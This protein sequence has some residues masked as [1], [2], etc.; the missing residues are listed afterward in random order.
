MLMAVFFILLGVT[1][2]VFVGSLLLGKRKLISI[3]IPSVVASVMAVI[4]Y[5]G[6]MI[7]LNGHLYNFGTGVIFDSIPGIVFAP[8]DLIIIVAT[9]LINFIVCYL[10]NYKNQ[11]KL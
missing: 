9:G 2:G 5:I 1:A 3:W 7:L 4:M 10:L 11:V 8:I 6:E